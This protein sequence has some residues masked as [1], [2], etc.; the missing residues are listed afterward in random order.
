MLGTNQNEL[1]TH[2]IPAQDRMWHQRCC[3][4]IPADQLRHGGVSWSKSCLFV[5]GWCLIP[6]NMFFHFFPLRFREDVFQ[7]SLKNGHAKQPVLTWLVCTVW[8]KQLS[9]MLVQGSSLLRGIS[10]PTVFVTTF[11]VPSDGGGWCK[12]AGCRCCPLEANQTLRY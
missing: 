10:M 8:A 4:K 9:R 3:P 6:M 5:R 11:W 1:D 7:G 2:W 12:A